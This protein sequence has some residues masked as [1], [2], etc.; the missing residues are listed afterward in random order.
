MTVVGAVIGVAIAVGLSRV[1]ESLLFQMTARDPWVFAGAA[2]ALRRGSATCR[3]DPR[4]SA[5]LAWIR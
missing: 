4:A 3:V 1:A 5:R 2:V